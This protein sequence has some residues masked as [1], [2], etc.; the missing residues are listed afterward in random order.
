MWPP[1]SFLSGQQD[2]V[3]YG[4]MLRITDEHPS[5]L[6]QCAWWNK[7][8]MGKVSVSTQTT[9]ADSGWPSTPAVQSPI[10]SMSPVQTMQKQEVVPGRAQRPGPRLGRA[11][12][13]R[14]RLRAHY[15][16]KQQHSA[17]S[18]KEND[19]PSNHSSSQSLNDPELP[20]E[21]QPSCACTLL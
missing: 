1:E 4:L 20:K 18:Y 19:H 12:E 2:F 11:L 14:E 13:L 16:E 7:K 9:H 5:Y 8:L 10:R 21:V 3:P 15:L 6:P 17:Q